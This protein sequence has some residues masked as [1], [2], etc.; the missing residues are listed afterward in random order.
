MNP[1]KASG[2]DWIGGGHAARQIISIGRAMVSCGKWAPQLAGAWIANIFK[3]KGDEQ[4]VDAWRGVQVGSQVAKVLTGWLQPYIA[5]QLRKFARPDQYAG[6]TQG[7]TIANHTL[8]VAML[9][10]WST[11]VVYLDLSKAFDMACREMVLGWPGLVDM[12]VERGA[13]LLRGLGFGEESSGAIATRACLYNRVHHVRS[14][15][16]HLR[17]T[18]AEQ[19]ARAGLGAGRQRE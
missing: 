17:D 18:P 15:V 8:R 14:W 1:R 13:Q 4:E 6:P 9:E 11:A 16:V 7:T 10:K 2:S 3:K 12:S 19:S 5:P